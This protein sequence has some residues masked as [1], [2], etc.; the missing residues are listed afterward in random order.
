M[1]SDVPHYGNK[2]DF[3][4]TIWI[5]TNVLF[6]VSQNFFL[7]GILTELRSSMNYL[8]PLVIDFQF[9]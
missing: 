2:P 1:P 9:I 8:S 3:E 5:F 4:F 6:M 7:K